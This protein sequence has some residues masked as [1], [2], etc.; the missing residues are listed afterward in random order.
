MLDPCFG[1]QRPVARFSGLL[2]GGPSLRLHHNV[3]WGVA[4][5][6]GAAGLRPWTLYREAWVTHKEVVWLFQ[7][8][9]EG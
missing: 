1:G 3:V 7:S 8:G 5:L 9:T 4:R 6:A 2:V